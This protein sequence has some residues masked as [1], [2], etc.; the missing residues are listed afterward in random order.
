MFKQLALTALLAIQAAAFTLLPLPVELAGT[1]SPLPADSAIPSDPRPLSA[2]AASVS[3]A[4]GASAAVEPEP[5][6]AGAQAVQVP[7]LLYHHLDPDA[8]GTNGAIITPE[9]FAA[10][11]AWLAGNGYTAIDSGELADWLLSDGTLPTKPVLISFDDG[12][13]SIYEHAYP[14]LRQY[15]LKMT[16]FLTASK[17]GTR[18]G[19]YDYL[20]WDE[21][22]E[23][24]AAGYLDLQSHTYDAHRQVDGQAL[25]VTWGPDEIRAD[26]ALLAQAFRE[27]SIIPPMA[28]AY[29]Y[30]AYDH[31]TIRAIADDG[32]ALGFTVI[33]GMVQRGDDPFTLRRLTVFPWTS[34]CAFHA[35]VSG[36]ADP[37]GCF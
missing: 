19:L 24:Q 30:G 25:L 15:G 3:P 2:P 13:R 17:V 5:S 32:F 35:M 31:E 22:H 1:F 8:D 34:M 10:Q 6:P 36:E 12:Y 14:I 4:P 27:R 28:Y 29:P 9:A 23:M 11:M 18:P 7:V 20:T 37:A 26:S 16:L 21:I 33:E